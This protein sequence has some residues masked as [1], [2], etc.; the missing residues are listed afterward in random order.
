[1][2]E[3]DEFFDSVEKIAALYDSEYY[4]HLAS[5]RD[6]RMLLARIKEH[7]RNSKPEGLRI[8]QDEMGV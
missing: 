3:E 7:F 5:C 1:M 6:C 8:P 4:G 2:T